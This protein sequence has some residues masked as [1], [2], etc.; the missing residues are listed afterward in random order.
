MKRSKMIAVLACS[1][2]CTMAWTPLA[3]Q[4]SGAGSVR[5]AAQSDE[6][7]REEADTADIVVTANKREER[8]KDV[9]ISVSV[10]AGDQLTRQNVNEVSDLTRS[11]AALNTA[12]PFGALSI[13][14]I[15][16][17]SFSRSS[18]GSVGVVVDNVALAGTSTNPPLLFDVARV[19]VL[20][21]P[22]GT[23]FGRNSSAGVLNI[24]TNAPDP[25]KVEVIAHADIATRNNYIG[26]GVVNL[27]ISDN[28][29]LRVAGSFAQAPEAHFNRTDQSW[30][31]QRNY[32]GR[33]RF[34]WEPTSQITIN[35]AGDY[36]NTD[37]RGG[38][39]W[40]VYSSTPG[41][42]LTQRLAAC[43]VTVGEE[44]QQG[45]IDGGNRGWTEAYGFS[46]QADMEIGTH[47]LTSVSAYRAVEGKVIAYDVDSVPVYRLNQIGPLNTHNFSQEVRLTSPSGGTIE[48]V[49]GLYYFDSEYDGYVEQLGPIATDLGAPFPLGQRLTTHAQTTSVAAFGQATVRL[50]PALRLILGARYGN[51]SV[52][53]RSVGTLAVGAVATI[54]PI[55]PITGSVS[56]DYVS[57]KVGAQFDV[58]R[59]VM[60]YGTYTRGYKGPS[61][62][63]QAGGQ[64][65]PI[66]VR[67]EIPKSGEVGIKA[68]AFGGR[69]T[70]S[71]AG[72]YTK[73]DDFQAQF[74]DP[75]AAAFI[76]GNAPSLTSKGVSLNV[77]GRPV[78]GLTLN[79]GAVYNDARY[80]NGYLV[81]CAQGQTLAQGCVPQV[82]G[83]VV[84][85]QIDDAGGNRLVGAPKWK[86]T[87]SGEYAAALTDTIQGFVQADMVYSSRVYWDAAFNP[88]AQ[89][90]PAALFGARAGVRF[91][92]ERFG[93]SVFGRN[94]FDTYRAASRFATPVA[95]QQLDPRAYSQISGPESRRVIGLSLDARF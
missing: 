18:E 76:F 77:Y 59:D 48:Y 7:I 71:L 4:Q 78:R 28:A 21:G 8:L 85:G 6:P 86:V 91:D 42:R 43:G 50:T 44:N 70:A 75:A 72:F 34:L 33:A 65:T 26:R 35:L 9:P 68:S 36:S 79:V 20:E 52:H 55:V 67:P 74:F 56:D 60:V 88:I 27:P 93:V 84:R 13:R 45:C 81:A 15:G 10:I 17:V 53:A 16:S 3:A 24:V 29:A 38:T 73:V 80:G 12:G 22:Q 64:T 54:R 39:P 31:R 62:N 19:E 46:A 14:G 66:L 25:T 23:L 95:A 41:S 87:A 94:L 57:Y 32:A 69:M 40:S 82:I 47:T 63:D 89:N 30:V 92:Q 37:K 2:A 11:A 1:T 49:G 51:E 5:P 90:A 61:I 58:T 83:G